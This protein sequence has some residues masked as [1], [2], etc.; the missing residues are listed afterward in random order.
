LSAQEFRGT[1]S[2]TVTDAQGAAVAK[3]KIVATETRTGAKS[4]T[5]SEASGAYTIPFLAPGEYEIAAEVPG[6]KRSVRQGMT[7]G[8]GAHPVIDVRLEVGA[9]TEAVTVTVDSPLIEAANASVGQMIT[10]DE[11]EDFPVNGRTPL[12]L[13][14]L[15]LGVVSTIEAG[16]QVRPLRQQHTRFVQPGRRLLGNQRAAL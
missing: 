16:V 11:V 14:Q 9:V 5:V 8:M 13:G 1:F 15:A 2:G 6:F 3:A 12:M 7:L 4:E 10:S